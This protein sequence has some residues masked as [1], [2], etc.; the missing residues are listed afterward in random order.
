MAES[1]KS[2]E[3]YEKIQEKVIYDPT[4]KKGTTIMNVSVY[5]FLVSWR[6]SLLS[7]VCVCVN[8]FYYG[9]NCI[10]DLILS[11]VFE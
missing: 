10:I 5:L 4:I 3:N 11:P 1:V 9:Y 8:H 7:C 6:E 2:L